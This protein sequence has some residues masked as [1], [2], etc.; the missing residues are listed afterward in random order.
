M[1]KRL[2]IAAAFV[3]AFVTGC[4]VPNPPPDTDGGPP[5][6][7]TGMPD[8]DSGD[9]VVDA[10][11]DAYVPPGD[12]G[13]DAGVIPNVCE[14]PEYVGLECNL[15]FGMV[16]TRTEFTCADYINY[17]DWLNDEA[18]ATPGIVDTREAGG[19]LYAHIW[20]AFRN[21][22]MVMPD[23]SMEFT[24]GPEGRCWLN[25]FNPDSR[26]SHCRV[27]FSAD[28]FDATTECWRPGSTDP[29]TSYAVYIGPST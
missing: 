8:I 7:D 18:G 1:E 16:Y 29:V 24:C 14:D 12:G 21:S 23:S 25:W 11:V 28:C 20:F 26:Y 13:T 10:G 2:F 6:G 17:D 4:P 5:P 22:G 19:V 9:P 27:S 15:P 3:A